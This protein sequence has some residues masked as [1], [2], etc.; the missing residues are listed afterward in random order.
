M[1]YSMCLFRRLSPIPQRK[2]PVTAEVK[3]GTETTLEIP[4]VSEMRGYSEKSKSETEAKSSRRSA[5]E[6]G[7]LSYFQF[8]CDRCESIQT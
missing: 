7:R 6:S 3:T 1:F 4:Q 8:E 5:R 2:V